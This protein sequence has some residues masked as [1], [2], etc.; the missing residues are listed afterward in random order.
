MH[1]DRIPDLLTDQVDRVRD[2]TAEAVGS[3]EGSVLRELSKL[4]RKL[5]GTEKHLSGRLDDIAAATAGAG[6]RLDELE[7]ESIGTT[8]PRRLF[9]I[10]VGLGAG[11]AAAYLADPDRG[12][13]RRQE[14][15]G[16]AQDR[17]QTVTD[18]VSQRARSVKDEVV[19]RAQDVKDQAVTSAKSV[20]E[21]AQHAAEDVK[22]EAQHAAE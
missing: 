7:A 9:W 15:V 4:G 1:L 10:T 3:N 19:D 11:A 21:E 16:Q 20:A 12:Q 17:V 22:D 14:I 13:Q 6:E 8:W 18:D 2:R 5:D